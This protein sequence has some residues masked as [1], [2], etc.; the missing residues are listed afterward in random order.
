[1]QDLLMRRN[2]EL[3][4]NIE[5]L[6]DS[7]DKV[8]IPEEL[9]PYKKYV[10]QMCKT[11][12][13][14]INRNIAH[15]RLDQID[16]LDDVLSNTKQVT[17]YVRLLSSRLSTPLLRASSSDR[18]SLYIIGWLHKEH[19]QTANYP[20]AFVDGGCSVFPFELSPV[21]FFPSAEQRGLL[22]QPLLFHEFGHFLYVRHKPEMDDL[23]SE[24][25]QDVTDLLVPVSQRNDRYAEEQAEKRQVIADTWYIWAQE[26][27]CDA[28]GFEIG[29]PSFLYAFS[30]FVGG[31]HQGDFSRQPKDLRLSDHPVTW[32]RVRFLAEWAA[33][34][35]FA[36][37]A[38]AI[39]E[40]WSMVAQ[41]IG[42]VEDYHGFYHETLSKAIKDTIQDMLTEASPRKHTDSEATAGGWSPT[43]DSPVRLLNWAWQIYTNDYEQYPT[44]EA[45]QIELL[46]SN[47]TYNL[48]NGEQSENDKGVLSLKTFA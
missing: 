36:D 44:W 10:V 34:S 1:M 14:H 19:P 20:P 22:Y 42:A 26:L 4:H 47:A 8:Q 24:L 41:I 11:L 27:F 32:L 28:V 46:I 16:I 21:Y 29:G 31:L 35:G 17:Q 13:G 25:R 15:L 18:L 5:V 23:V 48:Q 6:L 12:Q 37:L 45:E 30:S 9:Q 39:E 33:T 43:S 7:I 2:Q 38:K 3:I 40:E